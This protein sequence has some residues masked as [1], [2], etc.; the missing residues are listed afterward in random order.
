MDNLPNGGK[1]VIVDDCFQEI[2]PLINILNKNAIP[3]VYY[4]GRQSELP[5]LP[6]HGIRLFF[7]DLCFSTNTDVKTIVSNAC[8]IL[9]TILGKSNGPYLLI[10]WS[11]TGSD[12]KED[13]EE[14][15]KNE[16]YRPEFI[17]C[18]SKADYFEIKDSEVY[19]VIDDIEKILDEAD[20]ENI[21]SIMEKVT[22]RIIANEDENEK[23]FISSSMAKLQQE[24]YNGLKQAGLLS[25]FILW[26]NTIRDSAHK[27]VNEIY[28]QIPKSIS[29]DKKLPAMVYYLAKNRLEKQFDKVETKDKLYAALMELNELYTYFYFGDVIKIDVNEFCSLNIQKNMELDPSQE[30][31]N[32]WKMISPTCKKDDP[33]NIYPDKNKVFEFFNLI[34]MNSGGKTYD[35]V[36]QRLKEDERILYIGA[37]INGECET[38]QNKY[39]VVR[40]MPGILIPCEVYRE[41]QDEGVLK[42]IKNASDYIFNEFDLIEYKGSKYYLLFNINQSTFWRKEEID[43]IEEDEIY[44]T[45]HRKYY[46]KLRQALVTDFSKQGLDLYGTY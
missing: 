43:K 44:F 16:A 4:S 12:Y 23:V 37:N 8:N 18:L 41:Y 34:K 19:S 21:D 9:Q 7:L 10:I 28:T 17:L 33:G 30:K 40:I 31:F 14:A 39:P 20:V 36:T 22:D 32:T 11:S 35:E 27:V 38:A 6:L 2:L 1:V 5:N 29:I 24:L 45:L 26:E 13:L 42:A 25:L 3:V 15:L 46:L